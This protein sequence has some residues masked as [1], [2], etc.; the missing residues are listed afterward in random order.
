VLQALAQQVRQGLR[1]RQDQQVSRDQRVIQG[2][3]DQPEQQALRGRDLQAQQDQQVSGLPGP[4]V[5][6]AR[7]EPRVPQGLREIPEQQAG[8][9][10]RDRPEPL[11][12]LVLQAQ[13]AEQ[14]VR[15]P[16]DLRG[17]QGLQV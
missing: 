12:A 10:Q 4:Q 16:Q 5:L 13:Q 9:A 11:A 3:R 14:V 8:Q 2:T 7:T 15:D 6:R 17:R 1:D